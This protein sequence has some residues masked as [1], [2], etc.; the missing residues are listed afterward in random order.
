MILCLLIYL[1]ETFPIPNY[2]VELSKANLGL[3]H[4]LTIRFLVNQSI[5]QS[6]GTRNYKTANTAVKFIYV[7]KYSMFP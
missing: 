3:D 7:E 1:Q 2:K 6:K 4:A 5:N